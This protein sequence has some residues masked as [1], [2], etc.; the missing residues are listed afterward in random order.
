MAGEGTHSLHQLYNEA[1]QL[2][3]EGKL[4]EAVEK[5]RQIL[6][7]DPNFVLAHHAL[8][9]AYCS[10]G[11]FDAAIEHALKAC[12]LEPNDPFSYM[13]LSVTYRKA[14]QGTQ[15]YRYIQLAEEAM[16]RSHALSMHR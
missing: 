2:R 10:L 4:N 13:A 14:F 7:Q 9:V 5:Y 15:E 16:A 6:S 12:Q 8:A 11:N 3:A 1:Q